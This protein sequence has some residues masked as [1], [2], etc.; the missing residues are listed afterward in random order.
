[1]SDSYEFIDHCAAKYSYRIVKMCK[2]LAV[3][4]SGFYDWLDRPQSATA[5]RRDELTVLIKAIFNDSDETYGYRRV[6]A[7]VWCRGAEA[8]P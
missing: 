2:W 3:S 8:R 1:M 5:E 4:K 7:E 6:H